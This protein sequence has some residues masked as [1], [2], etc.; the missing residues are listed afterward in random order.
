MERLLD[1]YAAAEMLRISVRT[2]E[3]HRTTG[4]GPRFIRM[5]RLVRYRE[6]DLEVWLAQL[7]FKSTSE[8]RKPSAAN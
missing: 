7:L 6:S 3:R 8:Y 2:L 5:G 4:T 1:Q